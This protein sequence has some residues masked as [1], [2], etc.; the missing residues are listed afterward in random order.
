M[1]PGDRIELDVLDKG[2]WALG[3]SIHRFPYTFTLCFRFIKVQLSLG[4][5][6]SYIDPEYKYKS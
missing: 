2:Q 6:K 1:G 3:I 4:F 5:G